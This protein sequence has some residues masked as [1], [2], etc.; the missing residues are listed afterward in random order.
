[1]VKIRDDLDGVVFLNGQAYAAGDEVPKGVRVGG[2]LTEDGKDYGRLTPEPPKAVTAGDR[3][4]LTEAEATEATALGLQLDGDP[5]WVRGALAGH[6]L[7]VAAQPQPE[8]L[9]DDEKKYAEGIGLPDDVNPERIRGAIVGYEQGI[10]DTIVSAARGTAFDPSDA[11]VE[12]VQQHI[13]ENPTE[14]AAVLALEA[15]GKA[16]RTIL[17]EYLR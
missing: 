8:P 17:D 13:A 12:Q 4:P 10:A 7:G 11:N 6:L 14:T 16:R 5:E 15:A 3:T 2:H 1:M 9:T